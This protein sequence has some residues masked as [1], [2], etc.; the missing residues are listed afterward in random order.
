MIYI[1]GDTHCDWMSRL[2]TDAFPEQKEMTKDDCVIIT[3]DFGIW[4]DSKQERY[5]LNWLEDK[6]FTT[7]FVDG[8]HENY[9]LL[10]TYPVSEWHGG[11]VQFIRPHVIH[12]MRGQIFDIE[13]KT[14]FTFGGARSHDIQD[15]I[16]EKGDPKIKKWKKDCT[17]WFRV[18]HVSW[19]KEEL[20]SEE[21]M[22]EGL[23]NLENID[24]KVDFIVTHCGPTSSIALYSHGLYK[25]DV[26]TDYLEE[27][28]RKV[29]FRRWFMGHYHDNHAINYKEIILFEQIVRIV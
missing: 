24:N 22:E 18:N 26:L 25:P 28:R 20:P 21:E 2:N 12:L 4:N 27:I 10:N 17:K 5:E 23:M 3:G 29:D 16:L 14:F 1:T 6:P 11:K 13:E 15:G 9:D 8:N 19:W 7:L